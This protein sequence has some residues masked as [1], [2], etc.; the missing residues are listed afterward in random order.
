M[1]NYKCRIGEYG[2]EKKVWVDSRLDR[3]PYASAG[4]V[5]RADGVHLISYQTLVVSIDPEGWMSCTGTYSQT[6]RKHIGA[7]LREVAPSMSYQ[8]AKRCYENDEVIN[9]ET[10]EVLALEEYGKLHQRRA[11]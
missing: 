9:V 2:I 4:I 1:T 6:T 7:F 5:R 8:D 3:M 10:G 11:A